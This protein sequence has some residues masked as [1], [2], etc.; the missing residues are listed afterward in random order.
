[1][2]DKPKIV[3]ILGPTASGKT[4]LAIKLARMFDGEIVSV[5]SRQV[6]RG[7]DIGTGKDLADY[8]QDGVKVF[9]H[10]IDVT[11]PNEVFDLA[12]YKQQAETAISDILN[13]NK[14]PIVVGGSGLYLEALINN[15]QLAPV[16]AD[17][18]LR[19][20]LEAMS[21]DDIFAMIEK[22]NPSF[23]AKINHSDRHNKRR[24]IRYLEVFAQAGSVT[25][26]GEAKYDSLII[27]LDWPRPELNKRIHQRLVQRLDEQDMVEEV[28]NL[29]RQGLSW[30]RLES[31]GLEYKFI[32]WYL[33]EKI[34]YD[35]MVLRLERAIYQFAKRQM[36]WFKRWEKN[37]AKI[38]WL[39]NPVSAP[40]LVEKFL[41]II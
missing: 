24:L 17:A 18:K 39:D 30:Q 4:G 27:G 26:K 11:E 19:D 25:S 20:S 34:D 33:Q 28:N 36:T 8:S 38:N 35:E 15:Y 21:L 12:Q 29:N 9:Y 16:K 40:E 6:Y 13:R 5:D 2:K 37:G 31:F 7:M 14:L 23:S 3:V 10:L 1:M 32:A 22:N 41:N